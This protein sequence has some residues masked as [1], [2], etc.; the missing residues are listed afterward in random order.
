MLISKIRTGI[1]SPFSKGILLL[2]LLALFGGFGLL[3]T[4]LGGK[5]GNGIAWV[6]KEEISKTDFLNKYKALKN[7]VD[8]IYAQVPDKAVAASI[9]EQSGIGEDLS[10]N[11]LKGLIKESLLHQAALKAPLYVSYDFIQEKMA[12]PRNAHRDV[13]S[14][15]MQE[16][17][18]KGLQ[19]ELILNVIYNSSWV[20]QFI[21]NDA[22]QSGMV[23][24]KFTIV[25]LPLDHFIKT[26]EEKTSNPEELKNFFEAN[27]NKLYT[28]PAK[29]SGKMWT[30]DVEKFSLEMSEQ[31]VEDYYKKNKQT[32]YIDKPAQIKIKEIRFDDL[33]GKGLNQL[34]NDAQSMRTELDTNSVL[35]EKKAKTVDFF[36]RGSKEKS[37]ERAAFYLKNDGDISPV[38]D[39]EGK[40][41]AIVQRVA[42]KDA[43][44]KPFTQV[45]ADI[46]K[47]LLK[48][49]FSQDF[50]KSAGRITRT[51]GENAT[52]QFKSFIDKNQA[53]YE[54]IDPQ[55]SGANPSASRLFAL[56]KVGDR[57]PFM[58][59]G[60]GV[61]V[62]LTGMTTK[63]IM[64][65]E[66]IIEHVKKNLA[67]EKAHKELAKAVVEL[68]RQNLASKMLKAPSY[69]KIQKTDWIDSR[70]QDQL[71][72]FVEQGIPLEFIFLGKKGG[73]IASVGKKD[74]FVVCLDEFKT[75]D[76]EKE[77][78]GKQEVLTSLMQEFKGI[79]AQAFI[80]SLYRNAKID[81]SKS[82][83]MGSN[84]YEI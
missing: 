68:K 48:R 46:K 49:K 28:I 1:K 27:K 36:S 15:E 71:K 54:E 43:T 12:D 76:S 74:G 64:P 41:Y 79:T 69:G 31:E 4:L 52:E 83:D 38:I 2:I 51:E 81:T 47:A 60:K 73:M 77:K 17:M 40:G 24:K 65:F 58:H 10:G 30:F 33:K 56:K 35:F 8:Y 7:Y 20:P 6:N 16:A 78:K 59:D 55:I 32:Q 45:K 39:L 44:Y 29:R 75:I 80:A 3:R 53:K 57:L 61:I 63:S 26:E 19:N 66:L 34:Q 72:K 84:S 21:V 37:L 23:P 42:R 9:L 70:D 22:Y 5:T 67:R 50:Q 11:V 18:S 25:T 82:S 14:A 13:S 62:E